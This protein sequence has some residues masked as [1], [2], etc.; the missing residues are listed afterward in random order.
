MP[1][2]IAVRK[3]RIVALSPGIV[4]RTQRQE[5]I[6]SRQL[7]VNLRPNSKVSV[8]SSKETH[9]QKRKLAES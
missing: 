3:A 9:G 6:Q 2:A 8:A 7:R 1:E 5:I 4:G